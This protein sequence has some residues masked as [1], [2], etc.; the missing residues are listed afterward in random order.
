MTVF[1]LLLVLLCVIGAEVK[2]ENEF[3]EDYA[4]LE[5]SN[6]IKGIF[7]VLVFFSHAKAYMHLNDANSQY[8]LGV[9]QYLAQMIVVPFLF[10][11]GYGIMQSIMKKGNDYV[12]KIP[13]NRLLKVLLHFDIAVLLFVILNLIIK[14]EMTLGKVLWSLVGWESIGNSNWYILA[15]LLAYAATFIAFIVCRKHHYLGATVTTILLIGIIL[16]ISKYRPGYYYNTLL[17]YSLGIW[18]ALFKD[19]I[20]KICMKKDIIWLVLVGLCGMGYYLAH[21]NYTKSVWYYE[22]WACLFM[23]LLILFSM[24]ISINNGI[25]Q[26][27]GNHIFSIYILQRLPMDFINAH[28]KVEKVPYIFLITSF[29][30]TLIIAMIFDYAMDRLDGLVWR[31]NKK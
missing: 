20:D 18:Y 21:K 14:R 7:V 11:S 28:Y 15:I 6:A 9:Q 24:K 17:T 1:L 8:Y 31:K 29:I 5:K 23:L 27:F 22:L 4:S 10:F 13:T 12:K 30:I 19:K 26:F 2:K 25:L 16:Y 3:F